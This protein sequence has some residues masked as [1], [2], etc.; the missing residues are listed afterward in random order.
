M[1]ATILFSLH[2]F[3]A[4][5]AAAELRLPGAIGDGAV[6]ASDAPLRLWGWAEPSAT[7][8]VEASYGARGEAIVD[9]DGRFVLELEPGPAGGPYTLGFSGDGEREVTDVCFGALWIASGQSNMEWSIG[10]TA[11]ELIDEEIGPDPHLRWLRVP[12]IAEAE[13]RDEV[14]ASWS[15]FDEL[16]D[17]DGWSAVAFHFARRLR[18]ELD[19]PVG[20]VQATWGGT[21]VV[22]WTP[23]PALEAVPGFGAEFAV[24]GAPI[25]QHN[26]A[27]LWNGMLAPLSDL[28]PSGAI[29]YQGEADRMHYGRYRT[30]F[31]NLITAWRDTFERPELPFF[32]AQIAPF[33][34][35]GDIG[36]AARLREAQAMALELPATGMAVTLDVGDPLDIHPLPKR[37]VGERLAAHA[38][39]TVYGRDDVVAHG[40]EPASFRFARGAA[41]VGF[42]HVAGGLVTGGGPPRGFQLAGPDRAFHPAIAR[43][44]GATIQLTSPEVPEPVAAR[45]AFDDAPDANL[46]NGAGIPAAPF[47]SDDWP[48]LPAPL[49]QTAESLPL[50]RW[51]PLGGAADTWTEL[52]DGIACSGF[53]TG[54]LV[55]D[56]AYRDFVL[57]LEWRHLRAGGNAGIF[58]W[59]D[60]LPAVGSPF[61][62]AIEVQV[63]DGARGDWYTTDGDV[64]PIRGATFAPDNGTEG[65]QRAFPTERRQNPSPGW[66]HVRVVGEDGALTLWVNG[67]VV[68]TGREAEPRDGFIA[69]ESEG[70]PVEFRRIRISAP[71]DARS[72]DVSRSLPFQ[73]LLPLYDGVSVSTG[74]EAADGAWRAEDWRLVGDGTAPLRSTA[75]L[76]QL[77]ASLDGRPSLATAVEAA[78]LLE[79]RR[80]RRPAPDSVARV[81]ELRLD[82]RRS[83][84]GADSPFAIDG[85]ELPSGSTW[86]SELER[87]GEWNRAVLRWTRD[88]EHVGPGEPDLSV[89]LLIGD[90]VA[91]S[92]RAEFPE[93][94]TRRAEARSTPGLG[95]VDEGGA[96]SLGQ[97]V[98]DGGGE[99]VEFANLLLVALD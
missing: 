18:A 98:L 56:R 31:P 12:L 95:F 44:S 65:S 6:F 5:V 14:A 48:I 19:V 83:G 34:Y 61:A 52:D 94:A 25:D 29:W 38:L 91:A 33:D 57:E 47:R 86:P 37:P 3:L 17:I 11:S 60:P 92:A 2:L 39:R 10:T 90:A 87:P 28:R 32:F 81:L 41:T 88:T 27:V 21:P 72:D 78:L 69:L 75:T 74:W 71:L 42:S 59:C 40:P 85:Y 76:A 4:P 97:L 46:C 82:Y 63:M 77:A 80:S 55:S 36:E 99:S 23:G 51:R 66:N 15:R 49:E 70:S 9:A 93:D 64:F 68:T 20:I 22:A 84:P 13:P 67:R 62:R 7:I 58:V 89:E 26:P 30:L 24:R 50:E 96:W 8:A 35:E 16:L 73:A 45:Y 43:L 79:E 1:R 53:P 54:L